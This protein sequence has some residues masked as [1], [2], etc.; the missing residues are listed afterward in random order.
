MDPFAA[1]QCGPAWFRTPFSNPATEETDVIHNILLECLHHAP[2]WTSLTTKK[3]GISP[4][5][6]QPN[7]V[8]D[9]LA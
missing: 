3:T 8:P 4:G 7:L 6:Y 5:L 1:R 2:L 9:N